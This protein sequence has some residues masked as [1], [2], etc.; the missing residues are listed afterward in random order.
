MLR[1]QTRLNRI[2]VYDVKA[3]WTIIKRDHGSL[4]LNEKKACYV[5]LLPP[6]N[7]S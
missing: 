6:C 2:S 7:E 3:K 1:A 4:L 5:E